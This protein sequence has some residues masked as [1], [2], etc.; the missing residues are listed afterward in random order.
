MVQIQPKKHVLLEDHADRTASTR[1]NE[2]MQIVEIKTASALKDLENY[3]GIGD[4]CPMRGECLMVAVVLGLQVVR[5]FLL[6][7]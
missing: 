1:Q 3:V 5:V 2:L 7:T 6:Q 4:T